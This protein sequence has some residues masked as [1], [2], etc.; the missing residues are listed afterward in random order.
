MGSL[1]LR[2]RAWWE[3][4]D[5]TQKVV[6]VVGGGLLAFLVGITTYIAS[7]PKMDLLYGGL[8]ATDQGTVAQELQ[9]L[10]IPVEVDERGNV[11]VPSN[12]VA[13]ARGKLAVAGKQPKSGHAGFA[14]LPG[15]GPMSTPRIEQE[16]I[17]RAIEGELATTIESLEGIR[18]ARVHITTG[19][20]SPFLTEERAPSA[21]VAIT[22]EPGAILSDQRAQAIAQ[23]VARSVSGMKPSQVTVIDSM[24]TIRWDGASSEGA[25]GMG[26]RKIAA[27]IAEGQRIERDLQR[28]LDAAFGPGNTLVSAQVEMDFDKRR[29]ETVER[30]PSDTPVST[31]QNTETMGGAAGGIGGVGGIA[32]SLANTPGAPAAQ[33]GAGSSPSY[34]GQQKSTTYQPDAKVNS[35]YTEKATGEI[36]R[37]SLS[38]LADSKKIKNVQ[39]VQAFLDAYLGPRAS[40][41]DKFTAAVTSVEFDRTAAEAEVKATAEAGSR[42]RMQQII[43]L[44]PIAALLVVGFLVVKAIG[45]VAKE[46]SILVHA[47]PDGR[48]V[49]AG[50]AGG[51]YAMP[52]L[53][54]RTGAHAHSPHGEARSDGHTDTPGLRIRDVEPEIEEV[55]AIRQKLNVPLEQIKRMASDRPDTVAM[56]LKTWLLEE[57]R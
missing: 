41:P 17:R 31:E 29:I 12:L 37:M 10:G 57:R 48:L 9:K 52:E 4:A 7:K 42:A 50:A 21:S 13:E 44:L 51:S 24:G 26:D 28:K 53:G 33:P 23:I 22:E 20:D 11:R 15:L 6:T 3:T 30:M 35:T 49:S 36:V 39:A 56:L 16:N 47:L 2:I 55:D 25:N 38:V 18:S 14:D 27:Q 1:F 43:S 19:S 54:A 46:Q 5:R 32:G 45:K 8:D 40:Q 34:T